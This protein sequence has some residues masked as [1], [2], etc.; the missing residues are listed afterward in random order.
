MTIVQMGSFYSISYIVYRALGN[1]SK[2]L[3]DIV[4]LQAL[5]ETGASYI[6]LPGGVGVNESS[7]LAIFK[8]VYSKEMLSSAMLLSRGISFYLLMIISIIFISIAKINSIKELKELKNLKV[9][10][11]NY[12]AKEI[13]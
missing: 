4:F 10:K 3:L 11:K 7:F 13:H 1:N 6:P 2:S 12:S 9:I 8:G 5:I